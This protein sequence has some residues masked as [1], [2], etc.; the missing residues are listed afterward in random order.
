MPFTNQ[1]FA[2]LQHPARFLDNGTQFNSIKGLIGSA[3]LVK[4][5]AIP[6]A[7]QQ[8][9]QKG[10]L[11]HKCWGVGQLVEFLDHIAEVVRHLAEFPDNGTQFI[12]ETADKKTLDESV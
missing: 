11:D 5:G 4:G 6:W 12:T 7:H 3:S 2:F 8:F 1:L 10:V 9:A